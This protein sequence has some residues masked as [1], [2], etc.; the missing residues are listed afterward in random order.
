MKLQDY[1]HQNIFNSIKPGEIMKKRFQ[2][3]LFATFIFSL[4][5][6]LFLII[7]GVFFDLDFSEI[8]RLSIEGFIFTFVLVFVALLI[9]E[10]IFTLEEG[11]EIVRLKRRV[12]KLE[13]N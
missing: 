12:R 11:D 9:L 13:S 1:I 4:V 2:K 5:A 10:K 3:K 6:S 8:K 7:H